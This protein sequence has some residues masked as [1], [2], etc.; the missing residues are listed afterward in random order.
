MREGDH[1]CPVSSLPGRMGCSFVFAK[2]QSSGAVG[3]KI[4]GC[5]LSAVPYLLRHILTSSVFCRLPV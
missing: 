5:S 2:I 1:F 3:R 4:K